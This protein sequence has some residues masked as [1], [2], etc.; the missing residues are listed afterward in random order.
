MGGTASGWAEHVK[1]RP[2]SKCY[3]CQGS[4]GCS[5]IRP[6]IVKPCDLGDFDVSTGTAA[7]TRTEKRG[8]AL[9]QCR[10]R[11]HQDSTL[12]P[13]HHIICC[14]L[15]PHR[16]PAV[17]AGIAHLKCDAWQPSVSFAEGVLWFLPQLWNLLHVTSQCMSTQLRP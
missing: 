17:L 5:F 9:T 6:G 15:D 13:H 12:G 4:K 11:A 1:H 14:I 2:C 3:R 10:S 7:A 16:L 8:Y